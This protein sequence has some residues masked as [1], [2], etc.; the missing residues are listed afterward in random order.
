MVWQ[1]RYSVLIALFCAYLLCYMDRMV[2]AT[3]IP[4]MAKDFHLSPLAMGGVLSAFFV[5][6]SVMQIPGGLLAD[7]FGPN[8]LMTASIVGWSCFT[9]LTG[10]ANSLPMLL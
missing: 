2:I 9:A 6:Y 1:R 3:A 7:R 5:G 4:F 10:T 8:R